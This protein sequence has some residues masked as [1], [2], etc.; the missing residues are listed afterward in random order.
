MIDRR[1]RKIIKEF[2]KNLKSIRKAKG[3]SLRQLAASSG[4]DHVQISLYEKGES[5]LE[6]TTVV[7]LAEGLGVDPS[8]LFSFPC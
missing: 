2:G 1:K 5:N 3:L 6:M 4:V 7:D 8:E